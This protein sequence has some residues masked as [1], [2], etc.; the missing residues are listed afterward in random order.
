MGSETIVVLA[1]RSAST[2]LLCSY[3]GLKHGLLL[4]KNG[5]KFVVR[6]SISSELYLF[7]RPAIWDK[8]SFPQLSSA[9]SASIDYH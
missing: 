1:M 7:F 4:S 5:T 3:L 2:Q 8:H 6:L 9:N